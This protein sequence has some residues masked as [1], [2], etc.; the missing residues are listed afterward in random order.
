MLTQAQVDAGPGGLARMVVGG[1]MSE[2]FA[3]L[4]MNE[5]SYGAVRGRKGG[6][7]T[8]AIRHASGHRL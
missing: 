2:G 7:L 6:Y 4:A 3:S 1:H 5:V 8:N